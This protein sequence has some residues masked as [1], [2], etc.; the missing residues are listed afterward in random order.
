MKTEKHYT[1][2]G[3]VV[4]AEGRMLALERD[5]QRE[6]GIV[7]EV[8][9]PKGHVDPGETDEQAAL[10]EVREE[11]GYA[12]TEIVADLGKASSEFDFRGKHHVRD[13]HYYLMYLTSPEPGAQEPVGE[14]E[15]LFKPVW[16]E[17]HVAELCMTYPS[18]R[19]FIRRARAWIRV[20][21]PKLELE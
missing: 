8:R 12:G 5:V 11:S 1:A 10:R 9:L 20:N 2:G 17:P 7:H 13:E 14:E 16:F 15:A 4:D 18:E 3:V 6:G 21:N 19:V